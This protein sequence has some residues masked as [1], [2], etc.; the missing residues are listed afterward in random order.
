MSETLPRVAVGYVGLVV[1][2]AAGGVLASL[3]HFALGG[4]APWWTLALGLGLIAALTVA[5]RHGF[6]LHWRGERTVT[7]LDE[8]AI[9][10][11]LL[12][13][14]L[15]AVPI[16]VGISVAIAQRLARRAPIKALFNVAAYTVAAVVATATLI[17]MQAAGAH[18]IVAATIS[19]AAY[20]TASHAIVSLLLAFLSGS[21]AAKVFVQRYGITTL[22]HI[23]IGATVATVGAALWALHPFALLA[24][25]PAA[26][27]G[28]AFVRVNARA[29]REVHVRRRLAEMTL[30]L[31]GTSREEDV[32][33]AVLHACGDVFLA[34]RATVR[35]G[36]REW[37]RDFE[38]GPDQ[39][40]RPLEARLARRDGSPLGA[41]VVQPARRANQAQTFA[42]DEH[43]LT[44]V[45]GQAAATLE[46][47][48]SLHHILEL[49][50]LAESI[51]GNAPTGILALDA[52]GRIRQL[53]S[54]LARALGADGDPRGALATEWEPLAQHHAL[55]DNVRALIAGV[56]FY[57]LEL[58]PIMP[59]GPTLASSGVPLEGGLG[60]VVLVSDITAHKEAQRSQML[61]RPFVRRLVLSIVSKLHAP[62]ASIALVGREL[63]D[64]LDLASVQDYIAAFREMG[65]GNLH[66]EG[67]DGDNYRFRADDLLERLPRSTLP[68]C[69]LAL[70]F[71]E[72]A[73][74]RTR[75]EGSLG[76]EVQC[77]SQGHSHCRFVVSPR[78]LV[79]AS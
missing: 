45:A 78:P 38:S 15:G 33:D 3:V 35:V 32:A 9:V 60:S 71:L 13:L 43:L 62:R 56:P 53:N 22:A 28:Y 8:P 46:A 55:L 54:H 41:L 31:T 59:G 48:Q 75:R 29:E 47:A 7:T 18:V 66:Y 24:V 79:R 64:E 65:L 49:T 70:G 26:A 20:T 50:R 67:R 44:V 37:S 39:K 51:V 72:G 1:V 11:A 61:T 14:P 12:A 27:L 57:D 25:L 23:G 42:V 76:T 58:A 17:A 4:A 2:L 34:G 69:H 5:H 36:E 73:V 21:D 63:A 68:T 19:V 30:A 10:A 40:R 74:A 52:N 16:V 6:V 77:Q